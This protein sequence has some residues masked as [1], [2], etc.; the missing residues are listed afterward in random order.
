MGRELTLFSR[1]TSRASA[2][3]CLC[4]VTGSRKLREVNGELDGSH[5]GY[6]SQ[7]QLRLQVMVILFIA[8]VYV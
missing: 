2:S 4:R 3:L 7:H 5:Q 6:V 1:A 8:L